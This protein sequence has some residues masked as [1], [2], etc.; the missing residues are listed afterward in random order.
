MSRHH[1][2][3][4]SRLRRFQHWMK[5]NKKMLL[6]CAALCVGTAAAVTGGAMHSLNEQKGRQVTAGKASDTGAG[7]R[8]L[9]SNGKTYQ[10]NNRITTI[11]YAGLDS[12]D[13][14]EQTAAYG[15]KARADSIMLL[16]LDERSKEMSVLAISRDTMTDVH[17]YTRTGKDMGTYNTHLGYAYTYGDGGKASCENLER[18]VSDLIGGL[19]ITYYL[20]SNQTSIPMINSLVGG[21]TVTVPNS[22]LADLH[23]EL[24][25][26]NVVT[27]DGSNVRDFVQHRDIGETF[28]NSGRMER[29]KAF[30]QAFISQFRQ[31]V[32]DDPNGVWDS[33]ESMDKWM[34]TDI[35]KSKY[36]SLTDTINQV[37][38]ADDSYYILE[39]TD[40]QGELHDEFNYD[41]D[42]LQE[43]ILRLFYRE[44]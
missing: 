20:V 18:A 15:D 44:V 19:P 16:I 35:T 4:K 39:G 12:Q 29:Q 34:Q 42:A 37:S 14:L 40:S 32:K 2:R 33:L 25:E 24:T 10:Y 30:V 9:T 28:S 5:K 31:T 3:R 43:L 26:G 41:E 27:L 7:Y 21:V 17:R 13:P 36:L 38:F 22:D 1:H 23:Q 11:L 8:Y 6:C